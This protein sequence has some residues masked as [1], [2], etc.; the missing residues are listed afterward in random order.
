[1]KN[2][3]RKTPIRL[4]CDTYTCN[5]LSV[6]EVGHEVNRSF[7]MHYCE[8]CMKTIV[9]EASAMLF[10]EMKMEKEPEPEKVE[11]EPE[12]EETVEAVE[13]EKKEEAAPEKE[14]EYYI[15]KYCG[16]RFEKPDRLN[17]YRSHV[18]KCQRS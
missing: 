17:E 7:C 5:N 8:E 11:Q 15:C 6:Y 18:M 4:V 9:N 2:L 13:E 14:Q 16:E 3:V 1:M 10:P 12:K